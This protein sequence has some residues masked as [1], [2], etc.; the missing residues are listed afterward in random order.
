MNSE[1]DS[2]DKDALW[3]SLERI[4][5]QQASATNI[6]EKR[7][8]IPH[9]NP[10]Y[11]PLDRCAA[12]FLNGILPVFL[13][14]SMGIA[15]SGF[16]GGT[17]AQVGA[18]LLALVISWPLSVLVRGENGLDIRRWAFWT[19]PL[20]LLV[21]WLFLP[22]DTLEYH[23]SAD[24]TGIVSDRFDV[25][26]ATLMQNR[27]ESILSPLTALSMVLAFLILFRAIVL[28]E[29]H[30]P[31]VETKKA[32]AW[33]TTAAVSLVLSPWLCLLLVLAPNSEISRWKGEVEPHFSASQLA[34]LKVTAPEDVWK[35]LLKSAASL[36]KDDSSI[37]AKMESQALSL[38]DRKPPQ[39]RR[40]VEESFSLLVVLSS[41]EHL[42][43]PLAIEAAK[44]RPLF[45]GV[46]DSFRPGIWMRSIIP[47]LQSPD[48]TES[49]LQQAQADINYILSHLK[50]T[51]DELDLQIYYQVYENGTIPE[52]AVILM[53]SV[54]GLGRS[55][56]HRRSFQARPLKLGSLN[57]FWSPTNV[58]DLIK[59]RKY[60]KS[61]L[62]YRERYLKLGGERQDSTPQ[63]SVSM[64]LRLSMRQILRRSSTTR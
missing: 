43:T 29:R 48:R 28:I 1:K 55:V 32:G 24:S 58:L 26:F 2:E 64:S 20:S 35:P 14:L 34:A 63:E 4:A 41:R 50:S 52:P 45:D 47:W 30:F 3:L 31:W 62:S 37:V 18:L 56:S 10:R 54:R 5:R 61:W 15:L 40:E 59:K 21:P 38:L 25:V 42:K 33:R 51:R 13:W 17:I 46:R 60:L 7:A 57:L 36:P 23:L 27:L 8:Q 12:S 11:N 44:A 49:E 9:Y 6:D 39:T 53:R 16:Q 22:I 19:L